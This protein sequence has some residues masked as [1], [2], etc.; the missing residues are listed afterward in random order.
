MA[1]IKTIDNLGVEVSREWAVTQEHLKGEKTFKDGA[2][3]LTQA[4]IDIVQPAFQSALSQ[5][6]Q[7][8]QLNPTFAEFPLPQGY[9]QQSKQLFT[10]YIV[11]SLGSEEK[12]E[13][14]VQRISSKP[15][16]ALE[17]REKQ[18]EEGQKKRLLNLYRML[19]KYEKDYRE[20][21]NRLK[22][23]QRG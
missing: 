9:N 14:T 12:R 15:V 19:E 11:P 23:F 2:A 7:F 17:E 22:Q 10:S 20:I 8:T 3:V 13:S 16:E 5:L 1:D 18:D 6:L 21:H 4:Q